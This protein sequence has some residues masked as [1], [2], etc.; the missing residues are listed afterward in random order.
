MPE[1]GYDQGYPDGYADVSA[2]PL[3][4]DL[5]RIAG[6]CLEMTLTG[7]SPCRRLLFGK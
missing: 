6:E 5:T 2:L 4:A 3:K 1:F 7:R